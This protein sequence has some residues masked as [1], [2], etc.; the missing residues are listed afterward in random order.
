[1]RT[2]MLPLKDSDIDTRAKRR[3]V[4]NM[5]AKEVWRICETEEAYKNRIPGNLRGG[6]HYLYARV[7]SDRLFDAYLTIAEA[8]E[9]F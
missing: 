6:Y 1:M 3:R 9:P 4:C 5:I 8:F 2:L 7:A